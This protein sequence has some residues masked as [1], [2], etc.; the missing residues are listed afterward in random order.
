[1]IGT[2]AHVFGSSLTIGGSASNARLLVTNGAA[3]TSVEGFLGSLSHFNH[4]LI[5][6]PGSRWDSIGD[7]AV[8]IS[9][10]SNSLVVSN[11][12]QMTLEF[13]FIGTETSSSNNQVLVTG[14]ASRWT[15]RDAL[16]VGA[17]GPA[18]QLLIADGALVTVSNSIIVGAAPA[19]SRNNFLHI[20]NGQ[21]FVN[22]ATA[23]GTLDV[24]HGTNR[25]DAGFV[26]VDRLRVTNSAGAFE[27][28]GGT[29]RTLAATVANGRPFTVGNGASEA[30]LL[31]P[32]GTHS[33][34]NNLVIASNGLLQ[35]YGNITGTLIVAAGGRLIPGAPFD[36]LNFTGSVILQG[37]TDLNV[38]KN[39]TNL[40]NDLVTATGGIT[41]GGD[42][43]V[44]QSGTDALAGG[45]R[46][47]FFNAVVLAGSFSSI[48]LPPLGP[49]LS[50]TNKLLVDGS[51][52]VIG[53]A[54]PGFSSVGRAGTNF[55]FSGTNGTPGAN[56]TVLAATNV[57]LPLSNWTSIA[58]RQFD[59]SGAFSFTNAILPGIPQRFFRL[60]TP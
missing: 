60:R 22:N 58:T 7:F 45:D 19:T 11:G 14:S 43:I 44:T 40:L 52:E 51:I 17:S 12:G 59:A 2:G 30:L 20:P 1:M 18:N 55:V 5:S 27:L 54:Q 26:D 41:Y 48:L 8:G 10:S 4:A 21:L 34:A 42:L 36:P 9:G 31:L 33:F 53:V 49:G 25:F 46:F 35:A 39:G 37:R 3:I 50:W 32:G 29:L 28:N 56:Y 38:R 23:T 47:R 13:P 57:A 24:R 15:I 6:G 16:L